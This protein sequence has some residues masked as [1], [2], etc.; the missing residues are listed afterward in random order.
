MKWSR[1]ALL[2]ACLALLQLVAGCFAFDEI[3]SGLEEM[4]QRSARKKVNTPGQG[5][6]G[7]AGEAAESPAGPP[8]SSAEAFA[9]S[10]QAS[11]R[12]WWGSARSITPGEDV[13]DGVVACHLDGAE[14]YM[15]ELECIAR[16]GRPAS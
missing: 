15:L 4:Q 16:G 6:G 2:A 12:E 8:P 10:V 5:H 13:D 3:D 7:G 11:V 9:A 1:I 14:A